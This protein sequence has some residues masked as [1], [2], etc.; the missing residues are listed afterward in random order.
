MHI[1][2]K[3][4]YIDNNHKLKTC[5]WQIAS[6]TLP[7]PPWVLKSRTFGCANSLSWGTHGMVKI[8][9]GK[10]AAWQRNKKNYQNYVYY[11][12]IIQNTKIKLKLS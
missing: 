1:T 2:V 12:C 3:I 7:A 6:W 4:N 9:G 8:L 11:I 5:L 10:V